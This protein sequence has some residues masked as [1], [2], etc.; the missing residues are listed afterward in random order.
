MNQ[1]EKELQGN[2]KVKNPRMLM[3]TDDITSEKNMLFTI[4]LGYLKFH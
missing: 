1:L 4:C 2:N 3:L